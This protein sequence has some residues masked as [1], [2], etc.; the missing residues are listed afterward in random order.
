MPNPIYEPK[1][2]ERTPEDA[3]ADFIAS[4][5]FWGN[6]PNAFNVSDPLLL[7]AFQNRRNSP[8]LTHL[9]DNAAQYASVL[10]AAAAPFTGGL[11]GLAL[12]GAG[13]AGGASESF[14]NERR[15]RMEEAY[16]KARNQTLELFGREPTQ[17]EV[18]YTYNQ[19]AKTEY[20]AAIAD[21]AAN[22]IPAGKAAKIALKPV[23]KKLGLAS[24]YEGLGD[25]GQYGVR[26]AR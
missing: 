19:G 2:R 7:Q 12:L 17:E 25:L 3:Y 4:D 13:A 18:N 24:A 16:L 9:R 14:I 5:L 8:V 23:V 26:L 6:N 15:D 20:A 1:K 21:A 11:T 10:G 22:A